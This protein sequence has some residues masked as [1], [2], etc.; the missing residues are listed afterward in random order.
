MG[1]DWGGEYSDVLSRAEREFLPLAR[2]S[3]FAA[4]AQWQRCLRDVGYIP[5]A[6]A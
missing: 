5:T 4:V 3:S 1:W 6:V 2:E